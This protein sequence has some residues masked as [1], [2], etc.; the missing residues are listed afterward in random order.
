MSPEHRERLYTAVDQYNRGQYFDAQERLERLFN[1]L[2]KEDRPLAGALMALATG[3]HLHFNRGGGRGVL[4]L[5]RQAMVSLDALGE[6]H[7]GLATAE[8]FAAVEAYLQELDSRKKPG[9]GF[10]DRWLAPKIR[11][12]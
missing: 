2:E 11:Y 10:F 1:E 7:E 4:N 5:M 8:L 12:C 3:M 9:A 6:T